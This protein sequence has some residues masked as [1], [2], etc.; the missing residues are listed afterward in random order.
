MSNAFYEILE[1]IGL[2]GKES[3]LEEE[4]KPKSAKA[5]PGFPGRM[6]RLLDMGNTFEGVTDK[7]IFH[8]I[9]QSDEENLKKTMEQ[10]EEAAFSAAVEMI[11]KART[12]YI[13]GIRSCEPLAELLGFYLNMMFEN[14][15]VIKTSST[16]EIFEQMLR[17][18]PEDV[19]VGISFPRYSMRTLKALEFANSRNAGVIA[20]TD[21]VHSP[22]NLYSSCNLIAASQMASVVDS[23]TAPLS[24]LNA[25]VVA[26]GVRRQEA[27]KKNLE[28]LEQ[29]W[30]DY[31]FYGIDEME[32]PSEDIQIGREEKKN[33]S[34][35]VIAGCGAAGMYAAITAAQAGHQVL[36]CEKNE[37]PGKKLYI[38]GKRAVQ[39][40]QRL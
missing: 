34:K 35:V 7:E 22:L 39:C 18:G 17:I 20:V 2:K 37:K 12:I 8:A 16:S 32:Q 3:G 36:V 31:Q 5:D 25:L 23:L 10:N 6:S 27:M 15:R 21:N 14:V 19:V 11:Q 1:K 4:K 13:I 28:E 24:L 33:M 30:Q 26:L 38:T 29:V 40:H 9:L